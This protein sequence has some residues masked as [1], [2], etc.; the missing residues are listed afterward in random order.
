LIEIPSQ[1]ENDNERR[2]FNRKT[3]DELE[4]INNVKRNGRKGKEKS[5]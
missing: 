4:A 1:A 3:D 2:F 5:K